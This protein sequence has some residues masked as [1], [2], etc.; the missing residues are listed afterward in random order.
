MSDRS[1]APTVSEPYDSFAR[2][3]VMAHEIN[4]LMMVVIAN[5]ELAS[6]RSSGEQQRGQLRRAA[7]A[8]GLAGRLTRQ[9][10]MS[11]RGDATEVAVIDVSQSIAGMDS[12]RFQFEG[13]E[14]PLSLVLELA[15]TPL[16]VRLDPERLELSLINLIRNAADAMPFG[17]AVTIITGIASTP[18][19]VEVAVADT[20]IGIPPDAVAKVTEPFFTTK[21]PGHGTGLG[22]AV[23]HTFVEQMG[24]TLKIDTMP[25]KGT[26]VRLWFPQVDGSLPDEARTTT[27]A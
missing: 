5:V 16:R 14:I 6:M 2:H 24:G 11:V 17:G 26:T 25:S 12:L 27:A 21:S 7:W 1:R 9:N 23:V 10:L 8:A 15:S 13:R 18:G 19:W 4:N 22:M 3:A 20:G